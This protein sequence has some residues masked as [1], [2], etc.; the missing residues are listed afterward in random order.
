MIEA[1]TPMKNVYIFGKHHSGA[2]DGII[3]K[4]D[5]DLEVQDG[6]LFAIMFYK[7]A[8]VPDDTVWVTLKVEYPLQHIFDTRDTYGRCPLGLDGKLELED[9]CFAILEVNLIEELRCKDIDIR[10]SVHWA[11]LPGGEDTLYPPEMDIKV[12]PT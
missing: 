1:N 3:I 2:E 12:K 7:A 10:L 5:K 8:K 9:N 11:N 4:P 6:D